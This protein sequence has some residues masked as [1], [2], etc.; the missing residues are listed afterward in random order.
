M[1]KKWFLC[2]CFPLLAILEAC[3]LNNDCEEGHLP[4]YDFN[5]LEI[6]CVNGRQLAVDET[7]KLTVFET[8]IEYLA[9]TN[10]GSLFSS[11]MATEQCEDGDRGKKFLITSLRITSNQDWD[12]QHPAGTPLDDLV[13][14]SRLSNDEEFL[15]QLSG[16]DLFNDHN[17]GHYLSIPVPENEKRHQFTISVTKANEEVVSITSERITWSE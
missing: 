17:S 9:R 2:L 13:Q 8:E 12:D 11:A 6:Q 10:R 16:A 1:N 4:F 3:F 15:E 14:F 7:L 5:N